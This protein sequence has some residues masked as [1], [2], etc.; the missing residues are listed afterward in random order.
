M[1]LAYDDSKAPLGPVERE[2]LV[3]AV[4]NAP[5][6]ESEPEWLEWKVPVDP[7]SKWIPRIARYIVGYA[8]PAGGLGGALGRELRLSAPRRRAGQRRAI[9]PPGLARLGMVGR[10]MARHG[11]AKLG[12]G[13]VEFWGYVVAGLLVIGLIAKWYF[14][15]QAQQAN[16]S[17]IEMNERDRNR[18]PW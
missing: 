18:N 15:F 3:Q 5:S 10:R 16:K 7:R 4:I 1:T 14:G 6:G 8:K 17:M 11:N 12:G 13:P 2:Q 9:A